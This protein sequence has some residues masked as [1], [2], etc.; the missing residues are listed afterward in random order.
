MATAAEIRNISDFVESSYS[1]ATRVLGLPRLFEEQVQARTR[2]LTEIMNNEVN[3]L[4]GNPVGLLERAALNPSVGRGGNLNKV[5]LTGSFLEFKIDW[6]RDLMG[7]QL[8]APEIKKAFEVII[9][10]LESLQ[11]ILGLAIEPLIEAYKLIKSLL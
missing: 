1:Y 9:A 11:K 8:T 4:I 6:A 2:L 5:G 7:R 3:F 10:I